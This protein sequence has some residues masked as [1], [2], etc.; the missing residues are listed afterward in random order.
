MQEPRNVPN[1]DPGLSPQV[2][3]PTKDLAR[4][5]AAQYADFTDDLPWWRRLAKATGGP[6]LE[7]GCGPGRLLRPLAA[8]GLQVTGLDA[9][10]E[11]ISWAGD[12]LDPADSAAIQLVV[13]DMRQFELAESFGLAIV[14]CNTL[15]YF[16]VGEVADVLAA[17]RRHLRRGGMLGLD[18][19]STTDLSPSPETHGL[20][21]TF[22]EPTTGHPVQVSAQTSAGPVPSSVAVTWHYDELLPDGRVVRH[23][24]PATYHIRTPD[25]LEPLLLQAGFAD[26]AF[27]GSYARR[28]WTPRA[29]R[30]VVHAKVP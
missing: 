12:H 4:L 17:I 2:S 8:D 21:D 13:G 10:P 6:I 15:A 30:L 18:L 9:S 16:E 29:R 24:F 14:A 3:L 27:Y 19:P 23:T 1:R 26:C 20:V 22:I 11:M 25:A 7:L 28:P 5:M